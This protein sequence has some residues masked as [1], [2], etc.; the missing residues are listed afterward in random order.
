RSTLANPG[1]GLAGVIRMEGAKTM[2]TTVKSP[3][4]IAPSK[5]NEPAYTGKP[6]VRV[7]QLSEVAGPRFTLGEIAEI[8]ASP[9]LKAKLEAIDMG[10]VPVAGIPR[11]ISPSRL[12]YLF[13][14][15][16][17]KSDEVQLYVPTSAKVALKVQKVTNEQFVEAATKAVI[18][19]LGVQLKLT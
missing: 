6:D 4:K 1:D 2:A 17:L 5:S 11:P 7:N 12:S 16:G 3:I 19:Q 14:Q 8:K 15:A 13:Q 10:D 9:D 18:Q